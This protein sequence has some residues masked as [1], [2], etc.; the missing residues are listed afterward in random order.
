MMLN[1]AIDRPDARWLPS[2]H[3]FALARLIGYLLLGRARHTGSFGHLIMLI[4]RDQSAMEMQ[5][6]AL[7][8]FATTACYIAAALPPA[9]PLAIVL[10]IPLAA[11]VLQLPVV[12]GGSALRALIGDGNHIRIVSVA[13]MVLLLLA[14]S[15]V[16]TTRSWARFA[17]WLFFAMLLLN[18]AAAVILWLLRGR[19]QAAEERCVR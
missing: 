13:T 14:S 7:W 1:V 15:Y 9:L 18:G 5:F 12:L 19:V 8:I 16:A 10:A 6:V 17:A 4:D 11:V 3:R 2:R